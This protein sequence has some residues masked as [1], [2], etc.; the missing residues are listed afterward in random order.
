VPREHADVEAR[1]VGAVE[2]R[3]LRRRSEA[4]LGAEAERG[5][6]S[7]ELKGAEGFLVEVAILAA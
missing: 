7:V 1:G 2:E 4:A 3:R 5:T 6:G